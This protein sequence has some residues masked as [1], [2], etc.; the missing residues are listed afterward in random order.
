MNK[1]R[2]KVGMMDASEERTIPPGW[3]VNRKD[4]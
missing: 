3:N 1:S 2:K 4:G